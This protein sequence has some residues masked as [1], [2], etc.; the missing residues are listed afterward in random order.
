MLGV[1]CE[2]GTV[3]VFL[4]VL[5]TLLVGWRE[6]H[7]ACKKARCWFV[8][9]DD[10]TGVLHVLQL[11][12]LLPPPSSLAPIKSRME[13][14]WYWLNP[15]PSGKLSLKRRDREVQFEF[16]SGSCLQCV[17]PLMSGAVSDIIVSS[18]RNIYVTGVDGTVRPFRQAIKDVQYCSCWLFSD[19]KELV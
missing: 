14:F 4:S 11:Q 18:I 10:L 5:L 15:G 17:L 16:C 7:P 13:T 12:L 3:W 1:F 19:L 8:G 2:R 9:G 6:G